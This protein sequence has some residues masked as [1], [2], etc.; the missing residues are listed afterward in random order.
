MLKRT[1]SL[2]AAFMCT[3]WISYAADFSTADRLF[4]QR[5]ASPS[6][7]QAA[8]AAYES[9]IASGVSG[10]NLERAVIGVARSLIYEGEVLTGMDTDADTE[11][12]RTLF[13][14]CWDKTVPLME[15]SKLGYE[16]P[17]YYYFRAACMAYFGQVSSTVEN[18]LNVRTLNRAI[19]DG[20]AT[21]GG[22][23]YEG[24]GLNRVQA[25]VRSNPRAR[26]LPGGLYNPQ[27]ALRLIDSAINSPA[28][29]GSVDGFLFCENYRRK[30]AVLQ[31]LGRN[32]EAKEVAETAIADF[33]LFL[34]FEEIPSFLVPETKHCINVIQ[35]MAAEL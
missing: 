6:N 22:D 5:E 29:P 9:L 35:K 13:K 32:A 21:S 33:E 4:S 19:S 20:L 34:E 3:S 15:P 8:R 30:T 27:E 26:P 1:L 23:T 18:L 31:E 7:T 14:Q 2:T 12:R 11:K 17:A 10:A 28:Y 24:G 25:A 16:S